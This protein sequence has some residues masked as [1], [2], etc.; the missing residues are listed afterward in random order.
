MIKSIL[1][2]DLI[3]AQGKRFTTEL[4]YNRLVEIYKE[5]AP[6]AKVKY[7]NH[8]EPTIIICKKHGEVSVTPK[9]LLFSSKNFYCPKCGTENRLLVGRESKLRNYKNNFATS[10]TLKH[11]GK[12]TYGNFV[13]VDSRTKG[14]ITCL[15]HGDFLQTPAEHLYGS[16]CKKCA[17]DKASEKYTK[18]FATFEKE[19]MSVHSDKYSYDESTYTNSREHTVVTCA[20]HGEFSVTPLN[21]IN[22]GSGCPKCT[23]TVSSHEDKLYEAFPLFERTNKTLIHPYHLDLYSEQHKLAVEVNGRYWHSEVN[24]KDANYHINKTERCLEQ[25]TTLLHFWDDE[26][27]S[28]FNIVESMI[29]SRIGETEK[30]YARNTAVREINAAKDFLEVNHLQGNSN[31]SVIFGLYSSDE[32]VSVM[33]FGK[34]RFDKNHEWEIIR[35]ATKLNTTVVGGAS[36]LFKAFVKSYSPESVVTYADRRYSEGGVYSV[37]G[38]TFS[39]NSKPSY[40]YAKGT[41]NI[42]RYAAQKHKLPNLLGDKFDATKSESENMLANGFCKV[43]DCGNKVFTWRKQ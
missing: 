30:I 16:G 10:A 11:N 36:K 37:L 17:T 24:G 34:P 35:F 12:Y 33:T 25:D 26:I 31:H 3:M 32:L 19:A 7:V 8:L 38:F 21:H 18:S 15:K 43:Y 14:L 1:K 2:K 9:Q 13:Y 5:T 4:F 6:F 42:S 39:H 40:F 28:K 23:N 27:K 22:N 20:V 29:N 41:A